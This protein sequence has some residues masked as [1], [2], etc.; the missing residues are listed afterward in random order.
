[1]NEARVAVNSFSKTRRNYTEQNQANKLGGRQYPYHLAVK[2]CRTD[3]A[4][5]VGAVDPVVV[6][7]SFKTLIC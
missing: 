3:K 2:S 7:P 4:E 5:G 6:P 1:V